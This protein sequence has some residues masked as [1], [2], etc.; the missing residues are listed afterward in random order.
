[1]PFIVT[2]PCEGCI[3][4]ACVDVCPATCFHRGNDI[5]LIDP[6]ECIDCG[7]CVQECPVDAIF[8]EADVP[9]KWASYIDL[10]A[11]AAGFPT[12]TKKETPTGKCLKEQA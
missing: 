3:S 11:E 5:L 8:S 9:N 1:M 2:Q 10:N 6:E 4:T 12:I 7:L